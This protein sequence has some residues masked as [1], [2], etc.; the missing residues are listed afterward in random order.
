MAREGAYY[1][2]YRAQARNVDV[3]DASPA[4]E[5]SAGAAEPL[6]AQ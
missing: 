4:D 1:K 6:S 2:L 3:E 5:A